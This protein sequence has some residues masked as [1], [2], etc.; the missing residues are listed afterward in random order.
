MP[1]LVDDFNSPQPCAPWGDFVATGAATATEGMGI[2]FVLPNGTEDRCVSKTNIGVPF[3][4]FRIRA[5]QVPAGASSYMT[6]GSTA[7]DAEIYFQSGRLYF[8]HSGGSPVIASVQ[9]NALDMQYWEI[10]PTSTGAFGSYSS[11]G[12]VWTDFAT[13][14]TIPA[15]PTTIDIRIKA[16]AMGTNTTA[17]FEHLAACGQ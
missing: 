4:G 15:L 12:L 14:L 5:E 10:T 17:R 3:G 11:D 2:D 8:S 16:G 6:L 13:A 9:Y 1:L 7:L